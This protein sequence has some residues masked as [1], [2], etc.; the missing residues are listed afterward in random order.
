MVETPPSHDVGKDV[1]VGVGE[2]VGEIEYVEGSNT[3][4]I[5]GGSW[6]FYC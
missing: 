4:L 5:I 2:G 6:T 3:G 1:G